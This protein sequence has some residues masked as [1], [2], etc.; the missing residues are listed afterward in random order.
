MAFSDLAIRPVNSNLQLN[1]SNAVGNVNSYD[2][3]LI[4]P[5]ELGDGSI[6]DMTSLTSVSINLS[7]P[8]TA[9]Q[10]AAIT[11]TVATTLGTHDATG[12]RVTATRANLVTAVNALVGALFLNGP[13]TLTGNDGTSDVILASGTWTINNLA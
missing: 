7:S 6:A 5:R 13:F 4:V 9:N 1:Y 2:S 12:F 3:G 8:I 10:Q 11:Q